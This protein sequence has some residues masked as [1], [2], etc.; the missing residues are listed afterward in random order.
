MKQ[1]FLSLNYPN[2][3]LKTL[4]VSFLI[5]FFDQIVKYKIRSSGEFY[6]C[7]KG[8][9]FGIIIPEYFLWL[10]FSLISLIS[11]F[12]YIKTFRKIVIYKYS[13]IGLGFIF[14]GVFS[15]IIDRYTFHCVLDYI[16]PFWQKLPIFNIADSFI[17]LG[18]CFLLFLIYKKQY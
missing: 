8:I 4:F 16:L 6:I 5:L 14:G 17:F 7:N 18:G 11:L 12:F 13:Y 9:S 10:I 3:Q 1:K 15:N 2:Y